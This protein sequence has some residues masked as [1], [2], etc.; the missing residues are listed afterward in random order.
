MQEVSLPFQSGLTKL[1]DLPVFGQYNVS[2]ILESTVDL[3]KGKA[4]DCYETVNNNCVVQFTNARINEA[5]SLSEVAVEVVLPADPNE[6]EDVEE[7]EKESL[8]IKKGVEAMEEKGHVKRVVALGKRIQR[9]GTKKLMTL[10]PVQIT[11]DSVS[12]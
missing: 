4:N 6:E 2:Q 8:A 11:Y 12:A 10:R 9:R 3:I 1:K 7:I 5:I